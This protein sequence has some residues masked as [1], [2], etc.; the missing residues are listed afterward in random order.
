MGKNDYRI[1]YNKEH[2]KQIKFEI[3]P[4]EHKELEKKLNELG[5]KKIDFIRWAIDKLMQEK[6]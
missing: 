2:Y 6:Q 5:M 1:K 4:E 3:Y